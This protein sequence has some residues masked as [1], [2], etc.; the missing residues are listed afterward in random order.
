MTAY[1]NNHLIELEEYFGGLINDDGL[2]NKQALVKVKETYG[3][4]GHEYIADVIKKEEQLDNG[5]IVDYGV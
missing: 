4:H 5:I 1:Q 2:T 3:E